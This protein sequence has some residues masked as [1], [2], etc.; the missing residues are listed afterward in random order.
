MCTHFCPSHW[1][2]GGSS[3]RPSGFGFCVN[4]PEVGYTQGMST[5]AAFVLKRSRGA[6]EAFLLFSTMMSNYG[7]MQMFL[8]GLPVSERVSGGA[9]VSCSASSPCAEKSERASGVT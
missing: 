5:I 2:R 9:C 7:L 6:E 1:R 8:P 3:V 4:C